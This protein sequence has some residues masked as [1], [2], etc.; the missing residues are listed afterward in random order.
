M[1]TTEVRRSARIS[2]S[3]AASSAR[4]ATLR[5]LAPRLAAWPAKST[6][7][8]SGK[9]LLNEAPPQLRCNR[10]MQPNPPLSSTTIVRV[11]VSLRLYVLWQGERHRPAVGRVGQHPKG[12]RQAFEDLLRPGD[13]VP[14]ARDR[15]K[16]VIDRDGRV[17]ERL[18]LLQYGIRAPA[19]EDVA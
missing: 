1:T 13:A 8:P 4:L 2:G 17:A 16:A 12:S 7:G 9:R 6:R 18:D 11:V 19:R 15:P 3:A 5:D 14:P 10:S